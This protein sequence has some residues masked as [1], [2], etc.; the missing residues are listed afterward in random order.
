MGVPLNIYSIYIFYDITLNN[1]WESHLQF[2]I[3]EWS[4]CDEAYLLFLLSK[5]KLVSLL[6]YS[7]PVDTVL[8]RKS[9]H[10]TDPLI[11]FI[12]CGRW[13]TWRMVY[14]TH[15]RGC[16]TW[17]RFHSTISGSRWCGRVVNSSICDSRWCRRVV[18]SS[19][20]GSWWC[21]RVVYSTICGRTRT[22]DIRASYLYCINFTPAVGHGKIL[23]DSNR[24][25]VEVCCLQPV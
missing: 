16:W 25:A 23:F 1:A 24:I 9:N 20:C 15:S 19:I 11:Y 14:V 5:E 22:P 10:I 6:T 2:P 3:L 4:K 8:R 13:G 21:G 17:R 18:Y 12:S 7:S